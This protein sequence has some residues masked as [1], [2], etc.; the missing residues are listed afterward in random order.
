MPHRYFLD[1]TSIDITRSAQ[2]TLPVILNIDQHKRTAWEGTATMGFL[3]LAL[4]T[5]RL[6][7]IRVGI[8]WMFALLTYSF[9][10]ISIYELGAVAVL[11][12]TLIGLHH[13][14]SPFQ[15]MWGRLADR[16]TLWG[17]RRTPYIVLSALVGGLVFPLLPSL[18]V[19]LG[20]PSV[21]T[22][23]AAFALFAIF[24]LSMAANGTASFSLVAEVTSERE[25]GIV[26]AVG[27]T[28]LVLSAIIS[29]VV[30]SVVMPV[31]SAEQ[32]QMLYNL[33]PLIAFGTALPV[34]GIERRISRQEHAALLAQSALDSERSQSSNPFRLAARLFGINR[35]V[36]LFF[37]FMLL[38]IMGIFL[39]DAILEVFGGEVFNLIPAETNRFTQTWGSGVLLGMLL[40]GAA[41]MRMQV[42]KKLLATVGGLGT[43]AGLGTIAMASLS[44]QATLLNPALLAM[45]FS[46][47]MFNI[48]ALSMM[49]EMTIEGYTGLYM[50]IWGMAQG[51]GTG[52][53]NILSGALHTALIETH[54]L[55]PASAY[56]LIF[57]LEALM[58]VAAVVVLRSISVQEFKGLGYEDMTT[59]MAL[60]VAT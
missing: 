23:L 24:G 21:W 34:I 13:F 32:M 19:A 4:K 29:A 45:G 14:L 47:G 44:G 50:G 40:V 52:L 26:I 53:A 48:G 43:A 54:L 33:T 58:M 22:L 16:Y 38:A 8:G 6:S 2:S 15:I 49:M 41:S 20:Q 11:I 28:F 59:A 10:R 5:L 39:Q 46:V 27:H 51:I 30:A 3:R 42:P 36:R 25:R 31:Y 55:L 17:Y 56:G 9:N 60:D 18:A 1:T 37:L 35:Q 7:V 12:T 57:G